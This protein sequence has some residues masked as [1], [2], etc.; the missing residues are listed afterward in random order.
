[1]RLMAMVLDGDVHYKIAVSDA[2]E[3]RAAGTALIEAYLSYKLHVEVDSGKTFGVRIG[4]GI[5]VVTMASTMVVVSEAGSYP[6]FVLE[7]LVAS[8]KE[9]AR[10]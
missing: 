3:V 8:T 1:M 7:V 4:E 9:D 10:W 2:G 6:V 5:A